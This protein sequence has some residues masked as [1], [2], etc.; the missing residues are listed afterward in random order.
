MK[1]TFHNGSQLTGH[2][3]LITG[4]ALLSLGLHALFPAGVLLSPG[5]LLGVIFLSIISSLIVRNHDNGGGT[6]V[7][8]IFQRTLVSSAFS[9]LLVLIYYTAKEFGSL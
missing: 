2:I 8:I 3:I 5:L 1:N 9:T 7:T 4:V 6:S